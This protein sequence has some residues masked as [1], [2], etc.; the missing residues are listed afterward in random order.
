[1]DEFIVSGEVAGTREVGDGMLDFAAF[2]EVARGFKIEQ[3]ESQDDAR[4]HDM[5]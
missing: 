4:E 1:M 3:G 2:D 5:E